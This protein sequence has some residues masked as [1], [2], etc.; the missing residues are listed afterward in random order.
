MDYYYQIMLYCKKG[1]AIGEYEVKTIQRF[2]QEKAT[3]SAS[4]FLKLHGGKMKYLLLVKLLYFLE[5]ES[6]R[7]WER[8][9]FNDSYASLPWGPVV[10]E[11]LDLIRGVK[12]DNE[13]WNT[14]IETVPNKMVIQKSTPIKIK[15]LSPAEIGLISEI[16]ARFGNSDPFVLAMKMHDLPEYKDPGK[17]SI[18][19]TLEDMLSAVGYKSEEIER[20]IAEIQD[21]TITDSV[22][23][24]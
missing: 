7:R 12:E 14:Y 18:P 20:I 22:F 3:E 10:S 16:D 6:F 23:S 13:I 11:T 4:L 19:I 5:R 1:S 8:S 15:K 9:V 17:S 2:N 24:G 21:E